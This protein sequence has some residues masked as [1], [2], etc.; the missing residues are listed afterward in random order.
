MDF[1]PLTQIKTLVIG[2]AGGN[3]FEVSPAPEGY[4]PNF[5]RQDAHDQK[6][7]LVRVERD[8]L[9]A[10]SDWVALRAVETGEPVP[11]EWLAYRQ[12]LRD[13]SHQKNPFQIVWPALPALPAPARRAYHTE[14]ELA[15]NTI[16]EARL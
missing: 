13:V 14:A 9:L 10:A 5:D 6:W 1:N 8:R 2:G 11:P 16:G 4:D 3:R 12:A 7:I 15:A